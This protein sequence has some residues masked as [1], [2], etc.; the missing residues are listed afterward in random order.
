MQVG[1]KFHDETS[2]TPINRGRATL[3]L[4]LLTAVTLAGAV[5]SPHSA[6]AA[7][8]DVASDGALTVYASPGIYRSGGFEPLEPGR[9]APELRAHAL[10]QGK[11]ADLLS[12]AAGRYALDPGL[13]TKV[14]WTESRYQQ[15][16]ISPK[17]AVGVMQLMGDTARNL[18]VD[19]HDPSQNILGGAA[20]LRQML[21]RYAGNTMLALAA[22]NAGPGAVDHFGGVPPFAQTR[23]YLDAIL[24]SAGQQAPP[25]AFV[26]FVDQ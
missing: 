23:A 26:L 3:W 2:A 22:Y 14:A 9:K 12:R 21:D 15:N 17:G 6:R 4:R 7:V 10:P 1:K 25:L 13:L 20:Y 18:G 16:A 11:V 24:G 19:P 8:I 5:L